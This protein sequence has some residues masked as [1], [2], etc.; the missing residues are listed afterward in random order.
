MS[1]PFVPI[2]LARIAAVLDSLGQRVEKLGET[3]C[4]DPALAAAYL[5][6]LQ[7]VDFVAQHLHALAALLRADCMSTAV[8]DLGLEELAR[9]LS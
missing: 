1:A 3:L 5:G 9:Q 6:A 8:G 2:D 4:A 7:D